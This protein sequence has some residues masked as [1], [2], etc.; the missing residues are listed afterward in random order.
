MTCF[1]VSM[2]TE[3]KASPSN[4]SLETPFQESPKSIKH[5]YTMALVEKCKAYRNT[6]NGYSVNS[7]EPDVDRSSFTS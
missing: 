3:V 4:E 7:Y 2:Y 6:K 1:T 5:S